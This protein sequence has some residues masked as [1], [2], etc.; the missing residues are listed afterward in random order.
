MF[1]VEVSHNTETNVVGTSDATKVA[2]STLFAK[3]SRTGVLSRIESNVNR[4]K[5]TIDP[6]LGMS[7][8]LAEILTQ[9]V[10]DLLRFST[11]N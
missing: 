11:P 7:A 4:L 8:L 5:S 3:L 1:A 2:V 6:Y 9:A 10:L